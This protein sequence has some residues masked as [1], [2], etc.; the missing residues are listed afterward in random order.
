MATEPSLKEKT[1]KGL[2]WGGISNGL[3]QIIG[4]VFG[5]VLARILD[6]EDYGL[7][8]ML[9]IFIA[10]SS[11]IMDSGF[12]NAIINKTDAT[13]EDYNS[14]F[15]FSTLSGIALYVILF[16]SAP[17]ISA[18]FRSP[19]LIDLSRVLFLCIGFGGLGIVHNTMLLKEMRLKEKAQIDVLSLVLSCTVG[20]SL[21]LLDFSYWALAFQT[22]TYSISQIALR[23]WFVK[24]KPHFKMNFSPIREMLGFS[25]KILMTNILMHVSNHLFSVIFG[26]LYNEKEVGFY[27]QGQKWMSMGQSF[28]SGAINGVAQPVLVQ[29]LNNPDREKQVLRKM[30]R[31][32][33]FISF[34]LMLGLAFVGKEF[35]TITIGD[36]WLLASPFLQLFC[37]WGAFSYIWSLLT[38]LLISH[39]KSGIY[40]W[41]VVLT[42]IV[43]LILVLIMAPYGM[44]T[45]VIAYLCVNFITLYGWA[46]YVCKFTQITSWELIK[47]IFPF[48]I[49][50]IISLFIA[51]FITKNIT[52]IYLLFLAKVFITGSVY[53][54][55]MW[56][57]NAVVF[58]EILQYLIKK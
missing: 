56:K 58:K 22:V 57:S 31:F 36:K 43:Q 23:W 10:I 14:V 4:A 8:G 42:C 51:W 21:A 2:F 5:I 16:I 41:G 18:F 34:P 53:I 46:Y 37:I 12:T 33:A 25:S 15:W 55:I 7:V 40:M 49:I 44:Y 9:T 50:T 24:W 29:V 3:Q 26:R 39:G 11:S 47:D 13:F 45:M 20:L 30:L 38:N 1:A 17:L 52:N 19:E 35:I 28:I 6:V 48:F 32:G 54:L 27:V